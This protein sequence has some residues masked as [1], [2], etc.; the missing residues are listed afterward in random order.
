MTF[1]AKLE[2]ALKRLFERSQELGVRP[3]TTIFYATRNARA[4]AAL[5]RKAQSIDQTVD[6][7]N[8]YLDKPPQK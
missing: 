8:R 7:I 4:L 5:R 3:E 1:A 2:D 6:R